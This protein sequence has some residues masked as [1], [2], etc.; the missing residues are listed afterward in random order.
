MGRDFSLDFIQKELKF[1]WGLKEDLLVSSLF[2]GVLLFR[3]QSEEEK[4]RVLENGPWFLAGQLLALEE[5]RSNF[6]LN[7]DGVH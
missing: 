3:L 7:H 6:K 2:E 4:V 5:W 1:W